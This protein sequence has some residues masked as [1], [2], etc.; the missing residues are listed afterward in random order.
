MLQNLK[1]LVVVL[2]LGLPCLWLLRGWALNY[3]SRAEYWRRCSVWTVLTVAAFAIPDYWLYC[4]VSVPVLWWAGKHDRNPI[5]LVL[6]LLHVVPPVQIDVPI[7]GI[8]RLIDVSHY[9]W[10][11]MLILLPALVR[12]PSTGLP[13]PASTKLADLGVIG[14]LALII[15]LAS[16]HTSL[17]DTFRL[18]VVYLIDAMLVYYAF[19]RLVLDRQSLREAFA[20]LAMA[21]APIALVAVWESLRHWLLYTGLYSS[22]GSNGAAWAWLMRGDALRAQASTGHSMILG[23]VTAMALAFWLGAVDWTKFRWRNAIL[24]CVILAGCA[25]SISR[26]GWVVAASVYLVFLLL[27]PF[28]RAQVFRQLAVVAAFAILATMAPGGEKFIDMLP[29]VGSDNAN[30]DY[31]KQLAEL[32]WKLVWYNPWFG[33]LFVL[34]HMESLRQ[35]QG[36]I[37]T[38]NVYAT[39]ALV[40]GFV[41]LSL[42][43]MPALVAVAVTLRLTLRSRH[44]DAALSSSLA[45]LCAAL[46]GILMMM[47]VI[48]FM[49]GIS[50]FYWA[51][52]G[53]AVGL[54]R[55]EQGSLSRSPRPRPHAPLPMRAH[56]RHASR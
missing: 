32:S 15:G 40:Y 14:Y 56:N 39:V 37:D 30:I 46:L 49:S 27:G 19:S 47:S 43:V 33:D 11:S 29:F 52:L 20:C 51:M 18:T 17:T 35:G 7:V 1:A 8:N 31:R 9:R 48:S 22:W 55:L 41:G 21:T 42:F 23:F 16:M 25:A 28:G 13:T 3:M 34:R 4:L 44:H 5:A 12:Q 53:M 36:I 10:L 45:A 26:G 24:P 6:F 50:Y 38:V 2:V 54:T